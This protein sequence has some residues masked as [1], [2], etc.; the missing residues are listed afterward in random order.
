MWI[1]ATVVIGDE[2]RGHLVDLLTEVVGAHLPAAEWRQ[3]AGVLPALSEAVARADTRRIGALMGSLADLV[4]TRGTRL[5]S[6]DQRRSVPA[7][8]RERIYVLI[9]EINGG[10]GG[11]NGS[12]QTPRR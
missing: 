2:L 4:A 8:I 10:G 3:V 7:D 12:A 5:E 11:R 9:H 6:G 1:G